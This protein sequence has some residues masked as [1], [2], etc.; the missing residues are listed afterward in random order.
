MEAIKSSMSSGDDELG[1]AREGLL[2]INPVEEA[3]HEI[4][5]I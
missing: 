1:P 4:I 3:R 5:V 2:F